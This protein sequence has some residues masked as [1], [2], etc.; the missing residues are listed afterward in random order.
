MSFW[1]DLDYDVQPVPLDPNTAERLLGGA[2]APEDAPPGYADVVRLLDAA[3]APP[4]GEEFGREAE[5]VRM[6][7]AT[8]QHSSLDSIPASPRR[9]LMP[10]ALTRPRATAAVVAAGLACST[11]LAFAGSLPGAAQDIASTMLAKVGITVPGPNENAGTHPDERGNSST[12]APSRVTPSTAGKGAEISEFAATTELEGREK[13]AAISTMAS[14]GKSQAGQHGNAAQAGANQPAPVETPSSG[15]TGTADAA[16]GGK[17]AGGTS[18]ADTA[19]DG[20]N[21][22]GSGN[23]DSGQDTANSASGGRS[24]GGAENRP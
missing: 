9:S 24:S 11:S 2:I 17:S 13:G 16:S 10:F 15:G 19:S 23:A 1:D 18:T 7:A 5:T 22:A 21:S 14:G 3:A 8:V 4:T 12:V 20:R 6:M